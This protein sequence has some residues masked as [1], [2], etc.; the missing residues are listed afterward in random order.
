MSEP[1]SFND[2]LA[3]W[4]DGDVQAE[5]DLFAALS[6]DPERLALLRDQRRI[7]EDLSRLLSPSRARFVERVR[8]VQDRR[9]DRFVAR[10]RSAVQHRRRRR[11]SSAAVLAA[12]AILM[13]AIGLVWV[14]HSRIAT[15]EG[16]TLRAG[17][18]VTGPGRLQL[19][20]GSIIALDAEAR[21]TVL[22][23][24]TLRLEAGLAQ[25]SIAPQGS[26]RFHL[27]M[28]RS[29]IAV[30]GT[31]FTVHSDAVGDTLRVA[32]G[33]VAFSHGDV[34]TL[35]SAGGD[36][37]LADAGHAA[38]GM[39][40]LCFSFHDAMSAQAWPLGQVR[41]GSLHGQIES[42][43]TGSYR[44]V[45]LH[46]PSSPVARFGLDSRIRFRAQVSAPA[47]RL[48]VQ[49]DLD[50][51]RGRIHAHV[52][53]AK[54]GSWVQADLRYGEFT[55]TIDPELKPQAPGDEPLTLLIYTYAAGPVASPPDLIIDD[56]II[57]P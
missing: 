50:E 39:E 6:A 29:D 43:R 51:Q 11:R 45:R 30:I 16:R 54:N 56:V 7:D 5:A 25:A 26:G 46:R 8:A 12:V 52:P 49:I 42:N 48:T 18:L 32:H 1:I 27:R 28:P 44:G 41:E 3:A 36:L 24:Q 15:Y 14:Q 47:E 19:S 22:D 20:D 33:Q 38:P 34:T 2:A 21:M 35:V 55:A 37:F 57:A 31:A 17:S 4:L 13:I 10:T 23:G 40:R 53:L 9:T